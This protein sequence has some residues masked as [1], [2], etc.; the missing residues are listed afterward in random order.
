MAAPVRVLIGALA[1]LLLAGVMGCEN[2]LPRGGRIGLQ[3]PPSTFGASVNLQ[4]HLTVGRG[5]R[6]DELDV[7][8]E[9]D[10]ERIDLVGLMLGQRVLALHY[11]GKTLQTW[12]HAMMPD[13]LRGEDVLED[14]QLTLWPAEQIR[15]AFPSGW[16]IEENGRRRTILENDVP[17]AVI[18]Y[19]TQMRWSGTVELNNLRYHY[20]LTIR[21]APA[22]P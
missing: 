19:S 22:G 1:A 11:D 8:L 18:E 20:R 16:R 3:L 2:S 6:T 14:L 15:A 4:Q 5:G 7:A 13:E 17:V 9:I 10:S 12:R 21:T